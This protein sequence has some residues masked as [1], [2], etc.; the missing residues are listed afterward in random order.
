MQRVL[1]LGA[2]V[3]HVEAL[4]VDGVV[5]SELNDDGVASRVDLFRRLKARVHTHVER[6]TQEH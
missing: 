2:G 3:A 1:E 5:G 4:L 6:N